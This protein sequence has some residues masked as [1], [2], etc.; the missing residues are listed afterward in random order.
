[1]LSES[2][3]YCWMAHTSPLA[4]TTA[5]NSAGWLWPVSDIHTFR[6]LTEVEPEI[7]DWV[8]S[9]TPGTRTMI[10]AGGNCGVYVEKYAKHFQQ[11]FTFEPDARNFRCLVHNV[12]YP[13]VFFHRCALG[14]TPGTVDL[15][16]QE[17]HLGG[18]QVKQG[19]QIPVI[20]LDSLGLNNVDLIHLDIEGY[21]TYA[22]DGAMETIARC[23]PVIAIEIN[24]G[25][26]AFGKSQE[27]V[28]NHVKGYGYALTDSYRTEFLFRPV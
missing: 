27:D 24:E 17:N 1:M 21:E 19:T 14:S 7:P 3:A 11:V 5:P 6:W 13:N 9:K 22:L 25:C 28:I 18:T 26:Q 2:E 4:D 16:I 12:G 8:M 15:V 10:Q 23:L 20:T